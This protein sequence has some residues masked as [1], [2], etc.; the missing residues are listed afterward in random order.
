MQ[1]YVAFIFAF[2]LIGGLAFAALVYHIAMALPLDF[3]DRTYVFG[4][5]TGITEDENDNTDWVLAGI[6]RSSLSNSTE[7]SSNNTSVGT[8]NAAIDMMRP[9]GTARHTHTLTDFVLLNSSSPSGTNS[10]YFN[11]TSTVSLANG[12]ALDI[13][14]SIKLSNDNI[15]NIWID[16]ESVERHFGE[17]P[18]IFGIV[19]IPE[20]ERSLED[21]VSMNNGTQNSSLSH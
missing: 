13:P 9:D 2:L 6:W 3:L 15:V 18:T 11:G 1:N 14:T 7:T 5:I 21:P 16:P 4:P 12:P 10:T 17:S 20:F 8:F 19:A